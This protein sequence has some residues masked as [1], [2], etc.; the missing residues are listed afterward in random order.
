MSRRHVGAGHAFQ[1]LLWLLLGTVVVPTILL[2]VYGG[3]AI[4][5]QRT[6]LE[7]QVRI[8]HEERLHFSARLLYGTIEALAEAAD[9]TS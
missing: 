8:Q 7:E 3:W 5:N 4:R 1:R 2:S 6:A 9:A